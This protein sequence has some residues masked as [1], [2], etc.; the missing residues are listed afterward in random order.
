MQGFHFSRRRIMT[1][2]GV[3]SVVALAGCLGE[4]EDAPDPVSLDEEQTCD[5]CGMVIDDHPGPAGQIYFDDGRPEDRDGPA[6]FCSGVCTFEYRFDAEDD[7][8][9]PTETYLT[10]YSD[11][12]YSVSDEEEPFISAHLASEYFTPASTLQFVVE[13]DVRGAMG[14]DLIPFGDADDAH[15]FATEYDGTVIS[16]DDIS[17]ELIDSLSM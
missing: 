5:Q 4:D 14:P 13:T 11:A 17:R 16:E 9:M 10:D 15:G 8:S 1:V 6:W 2:A 7:G 3:G 12:D